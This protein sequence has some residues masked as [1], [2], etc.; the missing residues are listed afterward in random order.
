VL[1]PLSGVVLGEALRGFAR[2]S[3]RELPPEGAR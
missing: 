1:G 3:L 2:S